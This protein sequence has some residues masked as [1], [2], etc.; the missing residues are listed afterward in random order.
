[1]TIIEVAD[2]KVEVER[3]WIRNIY[4]R[5]LPTDARIRISAPMLMS[6]RAIRQFVLAKE[7]WIRQRLRRVGERRAPAPREYLSGELHYYMGQGY[8]LQVVH[9]NGPARVERADGDQI[10][11]YIREGATKEQREVA[12]REWYRAEMK[13][14]IAVLVARWEAVIGVKARRISI[15]RMRT[16]WG[17]C[18]HRTH[19]INFN[20]ELMKKPLHCIEYVVVHE[21]LHIIVRLHNDEFK[22]LLTRYLPNWRET[23][24][25]LNLQ[26]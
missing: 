24:R 25:E 10:I 7:A 13:A 21:L 26:R 9:G 20:L 8:R 11:L 17:S 2:L 19:D 4:L 23:K 12:M 3:K 1:M 15:K 6:E 16:I 18:N 5:V 14:L 22:A